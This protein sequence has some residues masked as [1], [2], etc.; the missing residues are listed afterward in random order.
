[1]GWFSKRGRDRAQEPRNATRTEEPQ[2]QSPV[3]LTKVDEVIA[4]AER[5]CSSA[6][7]EIQGN[8]DYVS[9]RWGCEAILIL[10]TAGIRE[11]LRTVAEDDLAAGF[12]TLSVASS[13]EDNN[14]VE[15]P[16]VQLNSMDS[17]TFRPYRIVKREDGQLALYGHAAL[18]QAKRAMDRAKGTSSTP[19]AEDLINELIAIGRV[20][21]ALLA[22]RGSEL[23]GRIQSV[24]S[25]LN[26][27]GG[28]ELMLQAH[29]AVRQSLGPVR[30]REL[31][32]A[33]DGI[34]TW[35]G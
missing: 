18:Y 24:G 17:R 22:P 11:L 3:S 5:L 12:G 19:S 32:A 25:A 6:D 35:H 14:E 1:M 27:I 30:A 9:T 16:Y 8:F 23:R 2:T 29:A 10:D 7:S 13:D 4:A 31:E 33:W 28:M 34:G 20:E 15:P 21:G 26:D